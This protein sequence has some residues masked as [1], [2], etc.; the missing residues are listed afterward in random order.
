MEQRD[1]EA[2]WAKIL[3]TLRTEKNFALFGLLATMNDVAFSD[4]KITVHLHNEAEKA[5]LKQHFSVLQDLA[6]AEVTIVLQDDTTAVQDENRDYIARLKDLFG[7][8]VEIV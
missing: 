7:D 2:I 5:M 1:L 4:G 6:G 3:R 8:K